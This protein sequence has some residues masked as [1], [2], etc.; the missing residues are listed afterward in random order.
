MQNVKDEYILRNVES[1]EKELKLINTSSLPDESVSDKTLQ[2]AGDIW[3]YLNYCPPI[4]QLL[5]TYILKNGTP[6][7]IILALLNFRN[8]PN[9]SGVKRSTRKILIKVMETL[10]LDTYEKIQMV[11]KGKCF[12]ENN[13]V[14]CTKN[15]T[16]SEDDL[17]LLG[18]IL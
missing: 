9:K 1:L 15:K 14:K 11:S 17:R 8:Y 3:T 2:H 13:F 10:K 16:F 4:E 5:I 12:I 7:E 18:L 6:K